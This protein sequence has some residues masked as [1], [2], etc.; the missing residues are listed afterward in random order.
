MKPTKIIKTAVMRL[1]AH[2][3]A[4]VRVISQFV[5]LIDVLDVIYMEKDDAEA[6]GVRDILLEP[7]IIC[8]LLMLP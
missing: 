7:D 1:L 2:G 5:L 3:E 6:R 4:C 8:M